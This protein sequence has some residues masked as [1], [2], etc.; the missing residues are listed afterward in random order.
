[1]KKN[2]L[3]LAAVVFALMT[4]TS[5][6]TNHPVKKQPAKRFNNYLWFDFNGGLLQQCNP[7]YYTVDPN[8]FPDC[9]ATLGLIYCEVKALPLE[10]DN[11]K[12][13]LTTV[14]QARFRPLL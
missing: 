12:P 10:E 6:F 5:A 7:D 9:P 4:M 2:I 13:D 8:N 14:T 3:C 11:T 1:M